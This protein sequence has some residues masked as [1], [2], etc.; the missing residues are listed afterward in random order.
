MAVIPTAGC[1]RHAPQ[2]ASGISAL[3]NASPVQPSRHVPCPEWSGLT[4]FLALAG[5]F[6]ACQSMD[7]TIRVF[8][9][10][11]RFKE[12]RK[13]IF[14]GTDDTQNAP[15]KGR[16]AVTIF[17]SLTT[18]GGP[19]MRHIVTSFHN[20]VLSSSRAHERGLRVLADVLAQRP[21]PVLGRRRGQALLL[22]L[23]DLQDIRCVRTPMARLLMKVLPLRIGSHS[24]AESSHVL[25]L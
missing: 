10:K 25:K 12:L 9:T 6:M 15:L 17:S 20:Y 21:L 3:A 18:R 14:R 16:L 1:D 7:N 23:E 11:D 24:V 13:K 22:G 19:N 2:R 5:A 4:G 8:S